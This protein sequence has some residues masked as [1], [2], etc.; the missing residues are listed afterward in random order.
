MKRLMC[1]ILLL[2]I[3]DCVFAQ[4]AAEIEIRQLEDV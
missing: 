2:L 4:T 3:F 1:I